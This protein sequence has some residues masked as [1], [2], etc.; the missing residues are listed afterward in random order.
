MLILATVAIVSCSPGASK[1]SDGKKVLITTIQVKASDDLI[2]ASDIEITYKGKGGVDT[3]D[4][5]TSTRWMKKIVN[6]SYPTEI[7]IVN[8]RMLT[9]QDPELNKDRCQLGLEVKCQSTSIFSFVPPIANWTEKLIE[10]DD[11]ASNKVVPYLELQHVKTGLFN[12][13]IW[14]FHTLIQKVSINNG[15]LEIKDKVINSEEPNKHEPSKRT[16]Q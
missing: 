13:G 15:K 2:A 6:D 8:Y 12:D 9:K 14:G 3:T 16:G 4:T 11:I 1:R 5:I 7:G 10:I